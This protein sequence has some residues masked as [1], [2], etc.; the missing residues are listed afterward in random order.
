MFKETDGNSQPLGIQRLE[1]EGKLR[2]FC[3]IHDAYLFVTTPDLSPEY[4]F[5]FE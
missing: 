5:L 1:M 3:R 2:L 4:T